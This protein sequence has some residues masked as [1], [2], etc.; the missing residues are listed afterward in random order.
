PDDIIVGKVYTFIAE[1]EFSKSTGFVGNP[2]FIPFVS[3][4]YGAFTYYQQEF[5]ESITIVNPEGVS[6]TFEV[7]NSDIIWQ[8]FTSSSRYE[9]FFNQ[10]IETPGCLISGRVTTSSNEPLSGVVMNGLP[11]PP[12][13]DENGYYGEIVDAGWSGTIVPEKI[14]Y[15]FTPENRVYSSVENDQPDQNFSVSSYEPQPPD[16]ATLNFPTGTIDEISPTFNWNT[17]T[18]VTWYFVWVNKGMHNVFQSWYQTDD[19]VKGEQCEVTPPLSLLNGDYTWWVQTWN[20]AGYGEW[21]SGKNFSVFSD[22]PQLPGTATLNSPVGT[23]SETLPIFNWNL[24]VDAT[25]Y[26]VW[27]NKGAE[28]VFQHW[29]QASDVVVGDQ[30]EIMLPLPLSLTSGSY[31]WWIQTWNDVG[32]GEWSSGKDFS[33]E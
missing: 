17:V 18:D 13:T 25:W 31:T 10:I 3:I 24:V 9:F 12:A 27:V 4:N 14:G 8:P 28:N 30:C 11:G 23:I 6:A 7:A 2:R 33:V 1:I 19:V 29:C 22:I 26:F 32:Y 21:S 20:D 16:I 15:T 5:G